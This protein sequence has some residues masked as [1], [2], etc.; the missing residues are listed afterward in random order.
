MAPAK[1]TERML[2]MVGKLKVIEAVGV[3]LNIYTGFLLHDY[4]I[5][6]KFPANIMF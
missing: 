6:F 5:M 1:E 2:R 3:K 4:N